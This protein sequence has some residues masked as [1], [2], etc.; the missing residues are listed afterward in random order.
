[1]VPAYP[2]FMKPLW[3]VATSTKRLGVVIT[4]DNWP[5]AFVVNSLRRAINKQHYRIRTLSQ[6]SS[7][8]CCGD[9]NIPLYQPYLKREGW[10]D[11]QL[12]IPLENT[13]IGICPRDHLYVRIHNTVADG[14]K[15]KNPKV[16]STIEYTHACMRSP[17]KRR[18]ARDGRCTQKFGLAT[19]VSTYKT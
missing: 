4:Q 10:T 8:E 1:M 7:A 13:L 19:K 11:T 15:I 6:M 17:W 9:T 14:A 3:Y 5:F 18:R 16:D 12:S 2:D